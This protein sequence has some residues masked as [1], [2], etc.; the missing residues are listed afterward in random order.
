MDILKVGGRGGGKKSLHYKWPVNIECG[1]KPNRRGNTG[2]VGKRFP[3]DG[4]WIFGG[5]G[6][7]G[8]RTVPATKGS[9]R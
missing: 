5:R 3:I 7:G 2:V 4:R 1:P 8:E 9:L 6:G